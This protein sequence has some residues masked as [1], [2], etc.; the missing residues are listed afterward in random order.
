M[1]PLLLFALVA[2]GLYVF[3]KAAKPS[4]EVKVVD[5]VYTDG[6]LDRLGIAARVEEKFEDPIYEC[7]GTSISGSDLAD[8]YL[9]GVTV[10]YMLS[11]NRFGIPEDLGLGYLKNTPPKADARIAAMRSRIGALP[12]ARTSFPETSVGNIAEASFKSLQEIAFHLQSIYKDVS[13]Y[14]EMA[15]KFGVPVSEIEKQA[16]GVA[17]L[18]SSAASQSDFVEKASQYAPVAAALTSAVSA[19]AMGGGKLDTTAIV[20]MFG[21]A[22]AAAAGA[23]VPVVGAVIDLAV[24]MYASSEAARD[25]LVKATCSEFK[26]NYLAIS[27]KTIEEHFPIPMHL[28]EDAGSPCGDAGYDYDKMLLLEGMMKGNHLMFRGLSPRDKSAVI[29][30]WGLAASLMSHPAVYAVFDKLG[31]GRVYNNGSAPTFGDGYGRTGC[32][33]YGGL[34]ASDEQVMLVAAPVAI[35]NGF[36]VDDF[37]AALWKRS[38]GWRDADAASALVMPA[39]IRYESNHTGDPMDTKVTLICPGYVANAYWLNLSVLARDAFELAKTYVP[40][41]VTLSTSAFSKLKM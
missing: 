19:Y 2:G 9:S 35:A 30:W 3:A 37:A 10:P 25:A 20:G 16:E 31:H 17:K 34:L 15:E 29:E 33:L 24:K 18:A 23:V 27:K 11:P 36:P 1:N 40:P 13:R 5:R 39:G 14:G 6:R 22:V 7:L 32:N 38:K 21:S 26:S 41:L 12:P 28:L 4:N 8:G